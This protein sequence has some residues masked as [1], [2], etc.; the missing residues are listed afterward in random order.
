[1]VIQDIPHIEWIVFQKNTE[2]QI[3]VIQSHNASHHHYDLRL[4]IGRVL[5]S[6]ALPKTPPTEPGIKRLAIRTEDHS[7]EYADFEGEIPE[8]H[9]G[10]GTV[11]IW[12]KGGL[13]VEELR[14][15]EKI[16]FELSGSK[17]QLFPPDHYDRVES[18]LV[19]WTRIGT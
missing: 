5:K 3:F 8:R 1:M 13:V 18:A 15:D 10:A 12:D 4:E 6:F 7:I 2:P 19:I 11:T 17:M 14:E 16:L 9:Y